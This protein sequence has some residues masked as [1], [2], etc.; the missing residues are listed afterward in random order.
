V[1]ALSELDK[2][3]LAVELQLVS[4]SDMNSDDKYYVEQYKVYMN[5]IWPERGRGQR[6]R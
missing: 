6:R 2:K 1:T 4:R 3:M 5:L